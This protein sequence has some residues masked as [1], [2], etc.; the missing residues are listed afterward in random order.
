MLILPAI[1]NTKSADQLNKPNTAF[2]EN[3]SKQFDKSTPK[4]SMLK[5]DPGPID[6][7]KFEDDL[8]E[9]LADLGNDHYT[10]NEHLFNFENKYRSI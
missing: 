8:V 1:Q 10:S 2:L 5:V 3:H 6:D 9:L 4:Q 7:F